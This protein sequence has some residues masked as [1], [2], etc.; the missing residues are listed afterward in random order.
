MAG[1]GGGDRH[2]RP[3]VAAQTTTSINRLERNRAVATRHDKLAIRH[4]ATH[5]VAAI[6]EWLRPFTS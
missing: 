4:E 3:G 1:S 5:H 6:S 2:T